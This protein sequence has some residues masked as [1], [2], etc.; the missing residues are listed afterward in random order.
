MRSRA[1][2]KVYLIIVNVCSFTKITTTSISTST[3]A[4]MRRGRPPKS[5]IHQNTNTTTADRHPSNIST[6]ANRTTEGTAI[7]DYDGGT[8][9]SES[10]FPR[11]PPRTI[12][13]VF[14]PDWTPKEIEKKLRESKII[15]D[16][17][18]K[19]P[20]NLVQVT[21]DK[22]RT[23][24]MGTLYSCLQLEHPPVE[25]EWPCEKD[26]FYTLILTGSDVFQKVLRA[27]TL[28]ALHRIEYGKHR[29]D[30]GTYL[31][32][33]TVEFP[34][35]NVEWLPTR[36]K[37]YTLIL[38]DPDFP[39]PE[40]KTREEWQH[41]IVGNIPPDDIID[42]KPI[43]G[44]ISA[45]QTLTEYYGVV[46]FQRFGT[47][48]IFSVVV[49]H[50]EN[51]PKSTTLGEPLAVNYFFNTREPRKLEDNKYRIDSQPHAFYQDEDVDDTHE[52]SL[53][54]SRSQNKVYHR[55]DGETHQLHLT[56]PKYHDTASQR[57]N[58]DVFELVLTTPKN[59]A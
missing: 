29:V 20:K 50:Q 18:L 26:S 44:N 55:E 3:V 48:M 28:E 14:G 56:S 58:V 37:F 9:W 11:Q 51:S 6:V 10:K 32:P 57:K 53:T 36:H 1:A 33:I 34:P 52:L 2:F 19:S 45:G 30:F 16:V 17:L 15:P 49:F 42:G 7:F 41:W 13:P 25:V 27:Y 59:R 23:V 12:G 38:T 47:R 46:S 40:S 43:G 8:T 54:T 24:H 4:E 39:T 21:Y 31:S 35:T 5:T 22:Q